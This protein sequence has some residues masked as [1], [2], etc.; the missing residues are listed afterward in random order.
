MQSTDGDIINH[1]SG[2]LPL[3]LNVISHYIGLSSW[4]FSHFHMIPGHIIMSK[5]DGV[6]KHIT[7]PS[8]IQN[9]EDEL[10]SSFFPHLCVFHSFKVI[11]Q[12]KTFVAITVQ[13]ENL[14]KRQGPC[15][16]YFT[17]CSSSE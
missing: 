2:S 6:T 12:R 8:C 11:G 1:N 9:V 5:M 15:S 13:C 10:E 14:L 3:L 7:L 16:M 4:I 17:A